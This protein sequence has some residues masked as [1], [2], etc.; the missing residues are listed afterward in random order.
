MTSAGVPAPDVVRLASRV[1]E[2]RVAQAEGNYD[3][4]AAAFRD[5]V[6]IQDGLPYTEPPYWYYPVRQSLGAVLMQA[7]MPAEAEGMFREAL[8]QY[9]NSAWALYGLK[10]AQR[11]QGDASAAA[12]TQKQLDAIWEGNPR[13]VTLSML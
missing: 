10:E 1:V 3:R 4:A 6:A 13:E 11:A 7:G 8:R 9:P 5:A 2:G 12:V